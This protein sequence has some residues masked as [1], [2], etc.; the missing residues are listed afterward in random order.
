MLTM[1]QADRDKWNQMYIEGAFSERTHPSALLAEWIDR[2]PSGSALDIACGAGRNCLFLA[3]HGF[4]VTGVDVSKVGLD[5]A[6][7]SAR[8][9]QLDVTWIEHDL[10]EGPGVEG[11]FNVVVLFRYLNLEL[12]EKLPNLLAPKG[13]LIVEEHLQT[14]E[15]VHGPTNPA[16]CVQ[17]GELRAHL[18]G[19][20]VMVDEE[21]IVTDPDGRKAA[22]ARFIG[23][24]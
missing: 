1:S 17:A 10:D 4:S 16:F 12:I 8:Q 22:L 18:D 6:A 15:D 20:D 3:R 13:V 23:R 24:R 11:T 19:L 5:R 2:L 9:E 14:S 7:A 21:G